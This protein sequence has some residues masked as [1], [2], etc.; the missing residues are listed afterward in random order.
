MDAISVDTIAGALIVAAFSNKNVLVSL[1]WINPLLCK[2]LGIR[3]EQFGN[4]GPEV[5]LR[6]K[7]RL[8][9]VQR[10]QRA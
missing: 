1:R 2:T 9:S 5:A 3:A 8:L 6:C 10:R 7:S 4:T